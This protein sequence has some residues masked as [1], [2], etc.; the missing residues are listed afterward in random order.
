[1]KKK[2]F[3]LSAWQFLALGYLTVILLGSVLLVLPF[4]TAE[5]NSTGYLDALFTAT[6]A[7][8]VTGLAPFDTGTHWSLFGQIVILVL[9]QTG[10]LGFMTFVSSVFFIFKR[11]MGLESRH[12]LMTSA[13]SV[14]YQGISHLVRRIF[15]G[16]ALFEFAGAAILAIRF[17]PQFGLSDGIYFSV[18]HSISA[19]CNAGFDL[20]GKYGGQSLSAYA[21]DPLVN[22]TVCALI[23]LGGLG[24]VVWG[25]VID[26]RFKYKKFQLNTRVIIIMSA[27]LIVVSTTLFTLFEW[28]NPLYADYNFGERVLVAL[29]NATTPRTAGFYVT[30]PVDFS[31]S[32]YFLTVVLMFIGGSSGS[33][34]GGIKVGTFAV[35]IMGMGSVFRGKRDIDIGK[36]RIEHTVVSQALA[37]LVSY[38][39]IICVATLT[40]CALETGEQHTFNAILCECVSALGTVGISMNLTSTLSAVPKIILILLMYTGRAGIL[41][42]AFAVAKKSRIAE[43]RNPVDNSLLIG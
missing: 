14:K 7:T 35:I 12:A 31:D 42:L 2:K 22:L 37:I 17:I 10:G 16:S 32:G 15:I 18:W 39:A 33:T 40:I 28:Q 6:S 26:C 19:F 4:A 27:I 21:T 43:V 13:G 41:T 29:F 34:A 30:N 25:D 20:M 23:I 36:K 38:L 3:R 9:V 8:C 11:G 1:M 24:F 5:G